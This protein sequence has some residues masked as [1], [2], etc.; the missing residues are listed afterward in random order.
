MRGRPVELGLFAV[1]DLEVEAK[2]RYSEVPNIKAEASIE[3]AVEAMITRQSFVLQVADEK[4]EPVGWLSTLDILRA[5]MED[6]GSAEVK[7]RSVGEFMRSITGEDYLNVAGELSDICLWA[8]ERRDRIPYFTTAGGTAG[9]L[10]AH[11]LLREALKERDR[12]RELRR[13]AEARCERLG[14]MQ[15]EMEKALAN[16]FADPKVVAQLKS[17]VEYQ[18][19][20]DPA[21][22]KVKI[23]GVIEEGVYRH[24]VNILRLLTELWEQGLMELA[25]MHQE[26]LVKAAIFH[27]LGKVQPHLAVGDMV[28][29][30]EA[31]EPGKFHAFRSASLAE[32]VYNLPESVVFLIKYHHHEEEEL[33]PYFPSGLLPMH[34]LFRLLDGLSAGLTRRGSRVN[35]TVKGTV[36]QVR[37]E[38]THPAYD[39]YLELDLCSGKVEV[40][41]LEESGGGGVWRTG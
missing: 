11:G 32:Q 33:P 27:D 29:P 31:F 22:G 1:G 3:E 21:T 14:R 25:G 18:D 16:L 35:L 28:D 41:P 34:R 13:E 26:T 24:V 23:T 17:I 20:Y 36:V 19:E 38:S 12:E 10:S 4:G 6:P 8:E 2:L 5:F 37:E 9:I 40:K 7:G 15:Q 30:K 39:R